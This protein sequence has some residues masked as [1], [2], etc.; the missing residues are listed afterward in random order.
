MKPTLLQVLPVCICLL[1]ASTCFGLVALQDSSK[2]GFDRYRQISAGYSNPI[3]R[4]Y[5]TSPLFYRGPGIGLSNAWLKRAAHRERLLEL[6]LRFGIP[7]A[8]I[9]ESE[10]IQPRSSASFSQLNFRYSR[11]YRLPI[12][13][14][15][16]NH[17]LAGGTFLSTVNI[18]LNPGLQN[19][20]TGIENLSNLILTAQLTRDISRSQ[21]KQLNLW[22]WKP[23][24]MPVKREIRFRVDAGLL[25]WNYRPGYTYTAMEEINGVETIPLL[26]LL[27]RYSWSLNGTRF[28]TVVEYARYLP[29]GNARS[30]SYVW[31]IATAPGKIEPFQMAFHQIRYT[32]YFKS[33]KH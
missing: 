17:L 33:N 6:D 15:N 2:S 11:L 5:A 25:N 13:K 27:K 4:D 24:L 10:F 18:R 20:A 30:W 23:R 8:K 7:S 14:G 26:W 12:L 29:N 28:G 32:W 3:Y 21:P 16:K 9:P 31:E 22:I 19:N 1:L